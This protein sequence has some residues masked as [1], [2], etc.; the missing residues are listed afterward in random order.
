MVPK[1]IQA[2]IE[3]LREEIRGHDRRYYIDDSPVVSDTEYD[4][5]LRFLQDLE[6]QYPEIITPDSP[7]QRVGGGVSTTFAS[8]KHAVPMVSLDNTYNEDEIRQWHERIVK[9]LPKS[10]VPSFV[11]EPKVDGLS[12]SLT[13]ENGVLK[14]GATRGDGET[15]EDVTG[16]VKTIKSVPLKLEGTAPKNLELRGEVVMYD[17]D[18]RKI[19][20]AE[21]K[22][23]REPF[24]NPRNCAAGSLRQKDPK[25]TASR[26]L[27]FIAHSFGVW[28][29]GPAI[30]R[31]TS[32]LR[33]CELLGFQANRHQEL[34]S[35]DQVIAYFDEFR[36]RIMPKLPFAVDGLV[37]KVDCY[38]QQKIL[39]FTAKS[40]RW[41]VAFKYPAQQA[42]TTV[43]E[44]VFS[45][46]RTGAITPVAKVK[47]VFCAGVTISS[48]SL[49]NFDEI[50]R[51]GLKVGDRVMIERA[52]EVIPKIVKVV[53]AAKM[54]KAIKP[55]KNCPVC[56]DKIEKDEEFVAY[57]C[58]NPSCPAQ[59]KRTFLHF[60]SRQ[61]MDIRGF[62][63]ETV[64]QL[65]DSGR[66]KNIAD[67][68]SLT[69]EDLLK[70]EL[71]K[72]KKADN[73]LA[74]IRD[75]KEQPLPKLINALGIR[76]V[77]EKT[78]ETLAENFSLEDL[79]SASSED[80][81]RI[82]E[83]GPIVADSIAG[84]FQSAEV[85]ALLAKLKKAGL[86]F[87]KHAVARTSSP[88]SGKTFV[89]TGELSGLTREQAAE[90]VKALGAKESGSVSAKTSYVVVGENPGS[91]FK[92][93][94]ALGVSILSEA[95]FLKLVT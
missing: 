36:D 42:S 41:A 60:A 84:F 95:E 48:V 20:E 93:A 76:Q 73:L 13:Y 80:L 31:H 68:Y 21:V 11:V 63:E 24:V 14:R 66:V 92:K 77:G 85:R 18:F 28:D 37:V 78:G 83:I 86:N 88:L 53:E 16:N 19:N 87:K 56:G 8:V 52:G 89:F 22:A 51:L 15:G 59:L 58:P 43:D 45:V 69:K 5:L 12:C 70:L 4:K 82:K 94:Q 79:A 32:F 75:S 64:D 33:H 47:P 26:H 9:L 3:R 91:K 65:V 2:E 39:G 72:D 23:G 1:K 38:K 44:V 61:A 55:P 71:W 10:E 67:I 57:Y 54:G 6:Q 25:I 30:D 49:H 50:G 34:A 81:Q 62:G 74:Q 35:I 46:G 27:R 40:P 17:E 29:G 7:T 90:K